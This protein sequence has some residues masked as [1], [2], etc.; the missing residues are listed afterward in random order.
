MSGVSPTSTA[1]VAS[2][3]RV[4]SCVF[5]RAKVTSKISNL[6]FRTFNSNFSPDEER[7][8]LH[9]AGAVHDGR[10]GVARRGPAARAPRGRL[11][12]RGGGRALQVVSA[13]G[14]NAR[15]AGLAAA[16]RDGVERQARR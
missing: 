11:Q 16:R 7:A 15:G 2:Q 12:R 6:K 14:D 5:I 1:Y 4:D 13:V 8:D 9:D 10:R 3:C